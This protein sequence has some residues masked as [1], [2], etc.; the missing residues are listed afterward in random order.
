MR[1]NA[2]GYPALNALGIKSEIFG[3][4]AFGVARIAEG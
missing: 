4:V 2:F 1:R 3:K